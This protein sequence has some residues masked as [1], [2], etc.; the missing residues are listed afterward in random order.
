MKI[1]TNAYSDLSL[2]LL[3]SVFGLGM[4][5]FHGWGKCEKLFTGDPSAFP[6]PL[7]LGSTTSL[8]FTVLAEALCAF[9]IAIGLFTRWAAGA[10]AFTMA[11]AVFIVHAGDPWGD[12]ELGILYLTVSLAFMMTGAGAYSI[13]HFLTTK[14]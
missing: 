1:T 11:V 12:R 7:G 2:L 6:D 3:R 10:L 9:L 8:L 13:D 14:R 5:I 4:L